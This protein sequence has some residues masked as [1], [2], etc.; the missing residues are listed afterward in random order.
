MGR[1]LG[2][3][4]GGIDRLALSGDDV[5]VERILDVGRR[6]GL[7]PQTLCVALVLGE[8]Q[9][10][11]AIAMEPVLAQLMV[12]GLNGARPCFVQ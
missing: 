10:R 8:E 3:R 1:G 11:G 7:A 2:P 5:G 4:L 6:V 12:R 9:L